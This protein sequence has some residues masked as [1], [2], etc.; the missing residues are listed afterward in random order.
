MFSVA[1]SF[2]FA[3][4]FVETHLLFM[5][6]LLENYCTRALLLL[7]ILLNSRK[8]IPMDIMLVQLFLCANLKR[9]TTK[10]L[11][12]SFRKLGFKYVFKIRAY[13]GNF[14]LHY[15]CYVIRRSTWSPSWESCHRVNFRMPLVEKLFSVTFHSGLFFF[16]I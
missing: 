5:N 7:F 10:Y 8:I 2:S 12:V 14:S 9:N 15:Y 6:C 16:L 3:L 11:H 1:G 13:V 4:T